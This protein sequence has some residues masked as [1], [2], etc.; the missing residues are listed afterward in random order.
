MKKNPGT[1]APKI[2]RTLPVTVR[3]INIAATSRPGGIHIEA[4]AILTYETAR[5][6][7][8]IETITSDGAEVVAE[9]P[10]AYYETIKEEQIRD[11]KNHCEFLG[12]EAIGFE[13]APVTVSGECSDIF[14]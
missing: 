9:S 8:R 6:G 2:S 14:E 1:Q 4:E 3:H 12:I 13:V 11:L 7:N 5:G 10:A